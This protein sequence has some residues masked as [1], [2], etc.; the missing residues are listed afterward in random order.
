VSTLKIAA[1]LFISW[2]IIM[3]LVTFTCSL[4][5]LVAQQS[6]RLG[7]NE[8]PVQLVKDTAIKIQNGQSPELAVPAE[9][10]DI[11]K[12]LYTFVMVF[13]S[14]KEL[15]ATSGMMGSIKPAYP[16]GVLDNTAIKGENR[17][18]WQPQVGLRYATVAKK[19]NGEYIVAGRSLQ[20]TESLIDII[21]R[22]V[23]L[24]WLA[25]AVCSSIA[26]LVIYIVAK[27]MFNKV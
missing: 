13:N 22:L 4:V 6:L 25:C 15:I 26:F 27:K 5:Y 10:I 21:T 8:L 19:F 2:V 23:G 9:K 1:K 7:A 16:K 3:F 20:E 24:E 17:V 11:S 12:S 14:N 18:T